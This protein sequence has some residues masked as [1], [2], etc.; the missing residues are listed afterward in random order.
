MSRFKLNPLPDA[1]L[2]ALPRGP[3]ALLPELP[4][5]DEEEVVRFVPTAGKAGADTARIKRKAADAMRADPAPGEAGS[6]L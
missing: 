4:D 2:P 1:P 5:Y 3:L 6:A